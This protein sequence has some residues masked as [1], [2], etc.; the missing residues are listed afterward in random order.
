M[1][2]AS[3]PTVAPSESIVRL[4]CVFALGSVN[5]NENAMQLEE[6]SAKRSTMLSRLA[7]HRA[8]TS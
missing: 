5:Q 4:S 6:V 1:P 7:G 2:R 8:R 3:S